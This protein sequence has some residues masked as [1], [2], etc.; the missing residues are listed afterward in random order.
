MNVSKM[1]EF[2]RKLRESKNLTQEQLGEMLNVSRSLISKWETGSKIPAV[3]CL[4]ALAKVFDIT[5]DEIIYGERKNN[6]NAKEI[7][8]LS[9]TIM[10]DSKKK[11]DLAHKM[12]FIIIISSFIFVLGS[13]FIFNY[14]SIK[15]YSV[16]AKSD[17]FDI[18]NT[19]MIISKNKSYIKFGDIINSNGDD[20]N[21]DKYIFYAKDK[22]KKIILSSRED[23]EIV[24]NLDDNDNYLNFNNLEKYLDDLYVDIYYQDKVETIKLQY[25]LEMANNQIF[26]INKNNSSNINLSSNMLNNKDLP[27]FVKDNFSYDSNDNI[28]TYEKEINNTIVKFEYNNETKNMD[29][30][31][32]NNKLVYD[33]KTYYLVLLDISTEPYSKLF[34]YDLKN[35]MCLYGDCQKYITIVENFKN[36]YEIELKN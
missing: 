29:M 9:A 3:D 5:V 22:D 4:T 20:T 17:A 8:N 15:V 12:F 32:E 2:I 13:Y 35:D 31:Y 11:I 30:L 16:G 28:Y 6:S 33:Y 23:G 10:N 26:N 1:A 34:I 27:N 24:R 7:E 14:N 25:N 18:K 21:Y 19:L 36:N